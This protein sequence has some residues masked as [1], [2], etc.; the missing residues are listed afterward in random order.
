MVTLPTSLETEEDNTEI[1]AFVNMTDM[2]AVKAR[3][4]TGALLVW[5]CAGSIRSK[6]GL[7]ASQIGAGG[8]I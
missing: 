3:V 5:D 7:Y 4:F 6:T 8:G 1:T 2:P